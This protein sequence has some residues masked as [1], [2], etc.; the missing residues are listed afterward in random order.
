ME[1]CFVVDQKVLE[2]VRA[3]RNPSTLSCNDSF[4]SMCQTAECLF[5]DDKVQEAFELVLSLERLCDDGTEVD[6]SASMLLSDF[7]GVFRAIKSEF[8]ALLAVLEHAAAPREWRLARESDGVATHFRHDESEGLV[9]VRLSGQIQAGL[10][11]VVSVIQE[12]DLWTSWFPRLSHS[13]TVEEKSRFHKVVHVRA[14][15]VG[16]VA[17]RDI[18]M[19]GRGYDLLQKANA[20]VILAR[21]ME[22]SPPPAPGT[23]RL[24]LIAGGAI[25][26]PVSKNVTDV[27]LIACADPK[28]PVIPFWLLNFVTKQL[29]GHFFQLLRE[30]SVN[31]PDVYKERIKENRRVYGEVE[32]RLAEKFS[33]IL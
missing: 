12:N 22:N 18:Y 27:V 32:K 33:N 30:R 5:L 8:A 16:P 4:L 3:S 24:K 21:E 15:G 17:A 6:E 7:C 23:V 26:V 11:A 2:C 10:L 28:L 1:S 20:V 14:H 29:A 31:L 9:T 19:D 13:A 25:L